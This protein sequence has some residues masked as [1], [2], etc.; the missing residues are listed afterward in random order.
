MSNSSPIE[1][2]RSRESGVI[3][4]KHPAVEGSAVLSTGIRFEIEAPPPLCHPACPGS[5]WG[6]WLPLELEAHGELQLSR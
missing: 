1:A 5:P 4:G 3:E 6:R 2:N